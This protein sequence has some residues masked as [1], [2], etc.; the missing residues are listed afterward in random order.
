MESLT[1]MGRFSKGERWPQVMGA[2]LGGEVEIIAEGHPGRTTAHDDPI[3][4]QH[5]NAQRCLQALLESHR[6]IDLVLIMLGTND[7]KSRFQVTPTEI[8]QGV[9]AL[10][11]MV[12]TST[13]GPQCG[14]PKVLAV[15]PPALTDAG[16][17]MEFFQGGVAKSLALPAAFDAMS[18]RV[19]VPVF[20][21]SSVCT[22]S[23]VDGIHLNTKGHEALGQALAPQVAALLAQ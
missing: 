22:M 15:S 5:K 4:G 10:I 12:A 14:P 3:E 6:P 11:H 19:G 18:E 16:C 8:A 17:L 9:Q 23:D 20:H 2:A 13:S 21:A 1:D 7:L